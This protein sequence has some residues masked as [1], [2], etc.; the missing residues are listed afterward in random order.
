[1]SE[2]RGDGDCS[3]AESSDGGDNCGFRVR[4]AVDRDCLAV[5]KTNCVKDRNIR[6]SYA[7]GGT[8]CCGARRA[9]RRDDGVLDVRARINHD[10]L[11]GIESFHAGNFYVF[12]A[13]G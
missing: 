1:M 2:G 10:L 5:A 7:G 6:R 11:A 3:G 12:R 8:Q 13:G 4:T 9:N